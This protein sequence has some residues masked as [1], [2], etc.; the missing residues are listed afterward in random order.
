MDVDKE[1][2]TVLLTGFGRGVKSR[3]LCNSS[4]LSPSSP[5]LRPDFFE[6]DGGLRATD[7]I[8]FENNT[9]GNSGVIFYNLIT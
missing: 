5:C 1:L 9:L 6:S 4:C 2:T 8:L 7:D 3:L